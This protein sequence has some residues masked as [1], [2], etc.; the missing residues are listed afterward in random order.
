MSQRM[1]PAGLADTGLVL[2]GMVDACRRLTAHRAVE[3]WCGEQP[4]L[5]PAIAPVLAQQLQQPGRERDVAVLVALALVDAQTHAGGVD[6]GELQ[7][8]EFAGTQPRGVGGHPVP[9]RIRT[10]DESDREYGKVVGRL[11]RGPDQ[12][13]R[14]PRL[15]VIASNGRMLTGS[16]SFAIA[17]ST[18]SASRSSY[19]SSVRSAGSMSHRWRTPERA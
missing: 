16:S 12:G 5:R 7:S 3:G 14:S 18:H 17:I 15:E 8:T 19:A 9:L 11:D 1:N 6:I 13:H 10:D 4:A 2:G